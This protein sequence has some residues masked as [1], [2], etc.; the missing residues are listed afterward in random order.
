MAI[1]DINVI[2]ADVIG[3]LTIAHGLTNLWSFSFEHVP[4]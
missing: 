1:N 4:L 3:T 2:E